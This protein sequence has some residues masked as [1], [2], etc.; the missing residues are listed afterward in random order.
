MV[1][2]AAHRPRKRFGQNFLH[3]KGVIDRIVDAF[4]ADPELAIVEIGPG[5]GALTLPLLHRFASV[6]VVEIDTDLAQMLS[7]KCQDQGELKLHIADALKFDFSQI[8]AAPLQIIGNLPYNISTPLMFHLLKQL[9]SIRFMLLM[10][11]NEVVDR[12][13]ATD[14]SASYGRLSVMIQSKCRVEKLFSVAPEAFKPVPKVTSAVVKLT[15]KKILAADIENSPLFEQ[16]VRQAFSQRRKT[17]RN[18]LRNLVDIN[19]LQ[20]LSISPTARPENL[21]VKN[22][23]DIANHV[24]H[25]QNQ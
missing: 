18:A 20:D 23:I 5:K 22:Y 16:I 7:L 17:L 6:N 14:N 8:Q 2:D 13:C 19:C 21:S 9:S 12:I 15:P 11:Q 25:Q 3:D 4:E 10:L 1:T 24:Y